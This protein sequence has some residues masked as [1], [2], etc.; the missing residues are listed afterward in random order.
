MWILKS[1]ISL[2]MAYNVP[3]IYI[4]GNIL[5]PYDGRDKNGKKIYIV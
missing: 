4:L 5:V 1:L 3:Y 2:F